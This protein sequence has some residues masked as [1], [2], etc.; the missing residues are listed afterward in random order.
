MSGGV[1]FL[2]TIASAL[3]AGFIGVIL[4]GGYIF[5]YGINTVWLKLFILCSFCGFIG[6]LVDSL[7]GSTLQAKYMCKVCGKFT[8]KNVHHGSKTIHSGGIKFIN[9]D[10]VNFTSG[11]IAST[12]AI[13]LYFFI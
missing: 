7:I 1:S 10:V 9:N 6:S 8:E 11:F 3:G 2:G 12:I 4:T 5:I 13:A